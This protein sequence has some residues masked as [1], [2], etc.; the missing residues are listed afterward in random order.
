MPFEH[1]NIAL[2]D[3]PVVK[4]FSQ[5]DLIIIQ[6]NAKKENK[7]VIV[8]NGIGVKTVPK[9]SFF[10]RIK[11]FFTGAARAETRA[12]REFSIRLLNRE[13][14]RETHVNSRDI[15]TEGGLLLNSGVAKSKEILA[16]KMNEFNHR[17]QD[18]KLNTKLASL[19]EEDEVSLA[20]ETISPKQW[21]QTPYT[22]EFKTNDQQTESSSLTSQ[23]IYGDENITFESNQK[24]RR[25][26]WDQ[27]EKTPAIMAEDPTLESGP[28]S[29]QDIHGDENITF[30]SN[31]KFRRKQWDQTEKTPE[32][33]AEDSTL[34]SG[35]LSSQDI[36]GDEKIQFEHPTAKTSR[37]SR[38]PVAVNKKTDHNSVKNSE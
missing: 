13:T 20:S 34:E 14:V 21:S 38:I 27:T 23:D 15:R 28:L 7:D 16:S 30:E 36:H 25:K 22:P 5:D 29:S 9:R 31:Q 8:F 12:L 33:M 6:N 3:A 32:I 19:P 4:P 2:R 35:P 17:P 37:S 26:Q 1:R 10:E 18:V 24:F 11:A